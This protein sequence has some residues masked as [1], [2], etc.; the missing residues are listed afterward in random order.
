MLLNFSSADVFPKPCIFF[1][2]FF[3]DKIEKMIKFF[4]VHSQIP[5][6]KINGHQNVVPVLGD[7]IHQI[8][9]AV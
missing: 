1:G 4:T 6:N 3:F 7:D 8:F 5:W 2:D 9:R